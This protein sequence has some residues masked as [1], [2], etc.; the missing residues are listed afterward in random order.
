MSE[1]D[2]IY[3]ND[4]AVQCIIGTLPEERTTPQ[5]VLLQIA[6][7]VDLGRAGLSD[8]LADTIDYQSLEQ[9][10]VQATE[11]AKCH[12]IERLAQ[13]AAEVC[14]HEQRVEAVT[15]RVEKPGTPVLSRVAVEIRRDRG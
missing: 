11:M 15:V 10:I 1:A 12:L 9:R 8:E 3:L 4:L 14:L 13:V 6:L 5:E 7:E 2:R